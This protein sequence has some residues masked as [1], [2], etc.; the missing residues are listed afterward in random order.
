MLVFDDTVLGTSITVNNNG[1]RAARDLASFCN[2]VIFSKVKISRD[3]NHWRGSFK[4]YG[5][6]FS[7]SMEI[8]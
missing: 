3:A 7:L 1:L 6:H 5:T 8:K 4:I 2:G